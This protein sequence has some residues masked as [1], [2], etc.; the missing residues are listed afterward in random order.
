M[1]KIYLII[2]IS[3][4]FN[5][6]I[7]QE[8]S[9]KQVVEEFF[10]AF[11][12]KD[13]I[14]LRTFIHKDAIF[15][16]VVDSPKIKELVNESVADFMM[17]IASIADNVTFEEKIL[18]YEVKIDGKLAHVWTPYEFYFQGKLHHIGANSF[19]MYNDNEKWQIIHLIDTRRKKSL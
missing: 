3:F 10:N 5:N 4:I 7:A 18:D 1:K 14:L 11:H 19:T 6:L 17:S 2:I 12:A 8:N 15:Q 13:T 16:T 9:P